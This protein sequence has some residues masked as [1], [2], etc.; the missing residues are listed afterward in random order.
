MGQD[1][2]LFDKTYP[3]WSSWF[4]R[5]MRAGDAWQHPSV[6][7]DPSLRTPH[8]VLCAP[9]LGLEQPV[10]VKPTDWVTVSPSV[11]APIDWVMV[12]AVHLP[13]QPESA[14]QWCSADSPF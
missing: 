2:F 13:L 11:V 14:V 6:E 12:S 1:I 4:Q 7:G 8:V 3:E 5:R 10:V 9:T